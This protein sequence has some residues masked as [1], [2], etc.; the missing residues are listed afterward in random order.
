VLGAP[1]VS[2]EFLTKA[3]WTSL[4]NCISDGRLHNIRLAPTRDLSF[5]YAG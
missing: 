4:V 3:I 5:D 1:A 2:G